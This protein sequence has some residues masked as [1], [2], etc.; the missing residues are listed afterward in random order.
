M[1]IPSAR[2]E[3]C[4]T[5]CRALADGNSRI[6][7][8]RSQEGLVAQHL[9]IKA[10]A[11]WETWETDETASESLNN[12]LMN[13]TCRVAA[14]YLGM[15]LAKRRPAMDFSKQGTRLYEAYLQALWLIW[16]V[17]GMP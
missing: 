4:L 16:C 13:N 5:P 11:G 2:P 12:P 6:G 17:T 1:G 14:G 8:D 7:S 3:P 10:E 15:S 9:L